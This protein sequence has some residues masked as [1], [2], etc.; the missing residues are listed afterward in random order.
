MNNIT[1]K[2]Y[3]AQ[4]SE[5]FKELDFS[6]ETINE[7][8]YCLLYEPL[9]GM[10]EE[11]WEN[12]KPG[13]LNGI[14]KQIENWLEMEASL[15][16]GGYGPYEHSEGHI[17]YRSGHYTRE[18]QTTLGNINKVKVPKV[19][20]RKDG[21]RGWAILQAYKKHRVTIDDLI[22]GVFLGGVSTRKVHEVLKPVL[23]KQ[24]SAQMVS[25]SLKMLD[26][27]VQA[28][29][30]RALNDDYNYLIFDGINIKLRS[31]GKVR[32]KSILVV[33]GLVID[34][35]GAI[36]REEIIDYL[37]AR[38]GESTSS[39][40]SFV[41]DLYMRGLEGKNLKMVV[42]DGNKG[43]LNAL[44]LV[45]PRVNKQ[46]CWQH[47]MR[48]VANKCRKK[49]QA[50]IVDSA[51]QIYRAE[52]KNLAIKAFHDFRKLCAPMEPEA[53]ECIE[54][55]LT[56]LL[57]FYNEPVEVWKK[58]RTTNSIER[59]FREVRRRIRTISV[60]SN[61]LSVDRI[62]YG[63]LARL[64]ENWRKRSEKFAKKS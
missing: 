27:E 8:L 55:D 59:T 24:Y 16:V 17:T 49:Y 56:E 15:A 32:K 4:A 1:Y 58:L 62:I 9:P 38:K 35:S 18:I 30:R 3:H 10:E 7:R 34:E 19:R 45:Y 47:K 29:H 46:R 44:D 42:T 61:E 60:F 50:L 37:P 20:K 22:K 25:I 21:N 14:K 40:E 13:I 51:R 41:N 6:E 33:K 31:G 23:G 36:I 2:K 43:L 64:N 54:K 52:S 5:K 48:N 28:W 39:W 11:F 26:K 53:V 57:Y 63:V 12:L